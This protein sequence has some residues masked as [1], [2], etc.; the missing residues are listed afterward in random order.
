[1]SKQRD[2]K[3]EDINTQFSKEDIQMVNRPMKRCSTFLT[4][5]EMQMKTIMRYLFIPVRTAIMKKTTSNKCSWECGEKRSLVR[6]WWEC[7]LVQPLWK[8][9]CEVKSLSH[10]WLFATPWTVAYQDPQSMGFSRQEC[11]SGLPFPS[12]RDL[13]DPGIEPGLLHC[14]QMLYHLHYQGNPLEVPQKY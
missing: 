3:I 11:W 7:K 14:R 5:R 9:V 1:M 2:W 8:T 4:I 13:P 10:V 12:A 6:C